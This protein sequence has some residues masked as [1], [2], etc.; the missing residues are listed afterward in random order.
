MSRSVEPA[1]AAAQGGPQ[2]RSVYDFLY[3]DTRR[4]GSYLSQFDDNGHLEKLTQS[5]GATVGVKRGYK[6]SLGGGAT[7]VGTGGTGTV[8]FE[9]GPGEQATEGLQ[10]VYDPLWTNA[11]TL[12]D[13]LDGESLLNRDITTARI[14]H[15]VLFSGRLSIFDLNALKGVWSIDLFKEN[16]IANDVRQKREAFE[17]MGRSVSKADKLKLEKDWKSEATKQNS[18]NL[19]VLNLLPHSVLC[20]LKLDDHSVW[21]SL[22]LDS[23][24]TSASDL[25]IKYGV[26]IAGTWSI[27]G[28]LDAL[29][30]G[31]GDPEAQ[32]AE[33]IQDAMSL[34]GLWE[35]IVGMA[36][37]VRAVLGRPSGAYGITPL[38]I[39]RGVAG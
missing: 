36:P 11:L 28:V 22:G 18:A 2:D 16:L 20:S 38:L 33:L 26:N 21:C 23:M 32:S 17:A 13:F 27:L 10:R 37:V 7:V 6:F 9:R 35:G 3:C 30:D 8:G 31:P 14:G 4:I 1:S 25:L 15:F 12:L 39:F 29:A 5:E 24:V 34:G 19:D